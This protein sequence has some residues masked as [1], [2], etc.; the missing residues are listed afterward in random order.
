V[1]IVRCP[2]WEKKKIRRKEGKKENVKRRN[3]I[4]EQSK[5]VVSIVRCPNWKRKER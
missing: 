3:R 1:R 4:N 2:N 5:G